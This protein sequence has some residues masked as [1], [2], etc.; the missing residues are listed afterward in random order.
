[1]QKFQ[2]NRQFSKCIWALNA[3]IL[4]AAIAVFVFASVKQAVPS[5]V[6]V[7]ISGWMLYSGRR[8]SRR[9]ASL[10]APEAVV[11][12]AWEAPGHEW[13]LKTRS[14]RTY[15]GQLNCNS[16]QLPS[17]LLLNFKVH[18]VKKLTV[19]ITKDSVD[20][21]SFKCLQRFLRFYKIETVM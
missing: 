12:L 10:S 14:G 9:Q 3:C 1:M 17:I 2:I 16:I 18:N 4:A 11:S 19:M 15:I 21:G 6:S 13:L 20:Q 7:L 5:P 8:F